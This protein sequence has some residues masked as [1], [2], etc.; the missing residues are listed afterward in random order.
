M[1]GTTPP[2]RN[3]CAPLPTLT[4]GMASADRPW[5]FELTPPNKEEIHLW[6]V[7]LNDRHY[8]WDTFTSVLSP[9]ERDRAARN[10][11]E[12]PKRRFIARRAWLRLVMGSYLKVAPEHVRF[13]HDAGGK[14]RLDPCHDLRFNVSDSGD[15]AV[16]GMAWGREVGV[17]VEI[18]RPMP[19][20]VDIVAR[21]FSPAERALMDA[22]AHLDSANAFWPAWT[23]KEAFGKAVGAGFAHRLEQVLTYVPRERPV[24]WPGWSARTWQ[25]TV[26]GMATVVAEGEGWRAMACDW[27]APNR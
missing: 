7:P 4:V 13:A 22:W 19:S 11:F 15:V 16:I 14:P 2:A 6:V 5:P 1:S 27:I 18:I 8:S 17:D 26:D 12:V 20:A 25:P 23:F 3:L 10:R 21:Y 24:S 9:E